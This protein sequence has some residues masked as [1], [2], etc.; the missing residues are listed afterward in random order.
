MREAEL[1][2]LR[3]LGASEEELLT[4]QGNL[5][6]TYDKART[7]PEEAIRIKRDV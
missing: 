5:A 2:T 4:V 3:R 6:I 7:A 1:S